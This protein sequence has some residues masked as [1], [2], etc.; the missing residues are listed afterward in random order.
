MRIQSPLYLDIFLMRHCDAFIYVYDVGNRSSFDD[1]RQHYE[2]VLVSRSREAPY[3]TLG[4]SPS[5]PPRPDYS[6]SVFVVANK[7][8]LAPGEWQVT[9][10]EGEDFCKSIGAIFIRMSAKTGEGGG[11]SIM[12]AITKQIIL[13]RIHYTSS[14][15]MNFPDEPDVPPGSKMSSYRKIWYF[16]Y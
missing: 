9:M 4:C 2:G 7:I 6:G 5:C 1:M 16:W 8:D 14:G 10:Q 11:T 12:R 3:C 15:N 13:K